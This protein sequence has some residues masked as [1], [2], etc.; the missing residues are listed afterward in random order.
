[1]K[2]RAFI[3][4]TAATSS[5]PFIPS[6]FGKNKLHTKSIPDEKIPN[7]DLYW[8]KLKT[9]RPFAPDIDNNGMLWHGH[10]NLFCSDPDKNITEEIDAAYLKDQYINNVF[11]YGEK[12]Y[13]VT[14]KSP[15]IYIYRKD[16]KVW[17][18]FSLP[19]PESNIWYGVRVPGDSKLYLYARN[20]GKLIIWDTES[21]KGTIIPYPE[22]TDL[23]SGFYI[24]QDQAIYSFTLDAKPCRL[25]RFDLKKQKYDAI[26][27]APDPNLEITGANPIGNTLYCAD[28]F[29]GRIFPFSF[30]NR[31]WGE[32]VT[33]PGIGTEYGFVGVGCSYRGLALYCLSTYNGKMKWDFNKDK[34]ISKEDEN[35][36]VDGNKHHFLNKYLV[37][38]PEQ[39]IFVYLEAESKGRYPLLCYSIVHKDRL[40]ITGFDIWNPEEKIPEMAR[41]GEL[42]V[43]HN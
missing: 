11:C 20:L 2:R 35:I 43:F 23:W 3:K 30:I 27:P 15:N 42:L 22:N 32:P 34:Y 39:N 4:Y 38:D 26:I 29:T 41:E 12:V 16:T 40:I 1:M 14:R 13:I 17:D 8:Q 5:I 7:M 24:E 19:E 25:I 31:K 9:R 28:R 33:A 37:Y 18:Q 36:G 21:D 10:K 6:I